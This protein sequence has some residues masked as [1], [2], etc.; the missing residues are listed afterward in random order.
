MRK[1]LAIV[2]VA[3]TG[4]RPLPMYTAIEVP[5]QQV[6]ELRSDPELRGLVQDV[7]REGMKSAAGVLEEQTIA[8]VRALFVE[9][10]RELV[11]ELRAILREAL[12]GLEP[13]TQRMMTTLVGALSDE[14]KGNLGPT[15]RGLVVDELLAN[16]EFRKALDET[17]R[18]IGK[19][20]VLG[21]NDA[22]VELQRA[23]DH[24]AETPLWTAGQLLSTQGWVGIIGLVSLVLAAIALVRQHRLYARLNL[25]KKTS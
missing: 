12:A 1:G 14:L 17:S 23:K 25:A 6:V 15:V 18:E 3:L 7:A 13:G 20:A 8:Q 4:C 11:A 24:G 16:A 21:A 9:M 19:Q 2:M 10:T 5:K 22:M